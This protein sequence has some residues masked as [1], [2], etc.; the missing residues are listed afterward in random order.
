MEID[1]SWTL[2]LDR[3]G[4]INEKREGD[5]VKNWDEFSF[6]EGTIKAIAI[7]SRFFGKIIIVTNQRGVGKNIMSLSDLHYI[8]K[9]MI[10][11]INLNFGRI[12]KIYY[13]IDIDDAALNRKPNIGMGLMAKVDYPS[14]EF[15]K[16]L[17]V[18]DSQSDLQFGKNL[19]MHTIYVGKVDNNLQKLRFKSLYDFACK[20]QN[21]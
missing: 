4:V 19:G 15:N 14:I 6:I 20:I 13:S 2:F 1:K 8:H 12:D 21:Q 5:Y 7:L 17:I 3:D 10:N 18:G 11:E 9:K 16:S